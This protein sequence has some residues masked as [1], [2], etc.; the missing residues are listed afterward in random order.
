MTRKAR[1]YFTGSIS[2]SMAP[3]TR[4]GTPALARM[5]VLAK[6]SPELTGPM[7]K[8]TLSLKAS[9]CAKFTALVGSPAVSR[10]SSSIWRPLMPP[11]LLISSTASCTPWFSAMA[12]DDSGPVSEDS[13]PTLMVCARALPA[14]TALSPAATREVAR[15]VVK[16]NVMVCLLSAGQ[17]LP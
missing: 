7:T 6:P 3:I 10:V 4:L 1:G 13:Q 16:R 15:S 8:C 17:W 2:S 9:C 12:A 5:G 14:E 11:A